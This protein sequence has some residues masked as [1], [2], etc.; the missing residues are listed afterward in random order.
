MGGLLDGLIILLNFLYLM[1]IAWGSR[2]GARNIAHLGGKL[3]LLLDRWRRLVMLFLITIILIDLLI[4][5]SM[6]EETGASLSPWV[7][8]LVGLL[9]SLGFTFLLVTGL[10]RRGPL[11]WVS[12][13]FRPYE[14]ESDRLIER[15]E[16]ELLH[17]RTCTSIQT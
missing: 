6:G 17:E 15:L 5:F 8:G 1:L 10:H 11:A 13:R 7:F 12:S 9:L 4:I 3:S 14:P 2:R 16:S